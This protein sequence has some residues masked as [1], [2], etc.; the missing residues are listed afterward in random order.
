MK[1]KRL[2]KKSGYI[3]FAFYIGEFAFYIGELFRNI[4]RISLFPNILD[5]EIKYFEFELQLVD[6]DREFGL[7]ITPEKKK[8]KRKNFERINKIY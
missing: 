7:T 3:N 1:E 5:D 6:G 8:E 4:N 2:L